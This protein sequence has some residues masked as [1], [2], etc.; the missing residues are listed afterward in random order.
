KNQE[1][2]Y[3]FIEWLTSKDGAKLWAL[4][5]GIPSNIEALS[6]PEVV[7]QIPQ[8]KLL[9]EVMPYR[10]IFPVLTV[11]PDMVPVIDEGIVAAVTGVK[12]PKTALDNVAAKFV[13]ILKNG[14]YLK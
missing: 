1:A 3:K 5:G 12:D 11:S 2:A 6:D 13:D 8:F 10:T 4:N 9:A 7:A 14:G